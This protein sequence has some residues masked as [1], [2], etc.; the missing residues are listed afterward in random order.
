MFLI[1]YY[2]MFNMYFFYIK[3]NRGFASPVICIRHG[4][5]TACP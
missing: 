3:N 1:Y 4:C 2:H 5:N